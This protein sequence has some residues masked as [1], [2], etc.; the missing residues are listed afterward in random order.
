MKKQTFLDNREVV[1]VIEV[2]GHKALFIFDTKLN[3]SK[4]LFELS[5]YITKVVRVNYNR[6]SISDNKADIE[7]WQLTM[8]SQSKHHNTIYHKFKT[9]A[10]AKRR[11]YKYLNNFA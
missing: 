10:D 3:C 5:E 8:L 11:M 1:V 2:K 4:L 9:K 6:L 7:N